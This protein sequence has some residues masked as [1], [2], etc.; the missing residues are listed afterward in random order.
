MRA[1]F[2]VQPR[3]LGSDYVGWLH[4]QA[5]WNERVAAHPDMFEQVSG[6]TSDI[7]PRTPRRG[8]AAH[9]HP[10]TR[11]KAGARVSCAGQANRTAPDFLP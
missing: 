7:L 3:T 11:P 9:L 6:R 5:I 10:G 4:F 2:A 8:L 1:S